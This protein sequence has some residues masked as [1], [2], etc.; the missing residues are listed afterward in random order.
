MALIPSFSANQESEE[1]LISMS[2]QPPSKVKKQRFGGWVGG[3]G[4]GH[5]GGGVDLRVFENQ[6]YSYRPPNS[7]I[8]F[9]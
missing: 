9:Y 4:V 3:G 5:G 6:E 1:A 2:F 7:I 8:P